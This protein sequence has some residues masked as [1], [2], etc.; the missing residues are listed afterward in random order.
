[1]RPCKI[2]HY[3]LLQPGWPYI[4]GPKQVVSTVITYLVLHL[5][6]EMT[7]PL[8]H[9]PICSI[10]RWQLWP[11]MPNGSEKVHYVLLRMVAVY[12]RPYY[13]LHNTYS[14]VSHLNTSCW[15]ILTKLSKLSLRSRQNSLTPGCRH[16]GT[17][18][19][20]RGHQTSSYVL[21]I[22]GITELWIFSVWS[23]R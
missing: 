1:M 3:K 7:V 8:L 19:D 5:Q 22:D 14:R 4:C 21:P 16:S 23:D 2:R 9:G 11:W 13:A 17:H 6:T 10:R 20:T 15:Q 18:E 12:I